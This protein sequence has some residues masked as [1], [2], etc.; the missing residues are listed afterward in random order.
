MNLKNKTQALN[1]IRIKYLTTKNKALSILVSLLIFV[2]IAIA[3]PLIALAIGIFYLLLFIWASQR[4][5]RGSMNESEL[6]SVNEDD[7]NDKT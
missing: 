6:K 3:I 1:Q 7:F 4:K 2:F 5:K